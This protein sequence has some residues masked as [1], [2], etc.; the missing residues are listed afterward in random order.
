MQTAS[1]KSILLVQMAAIATGA[2]RVAWL[3]QGRNNSE[4]LT[5]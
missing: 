4:T 3:W 1:P 5:C 2:E